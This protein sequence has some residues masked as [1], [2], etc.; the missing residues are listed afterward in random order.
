MAQLNPMLVRLQ[1]KIE[2]YNKDVQRKIDDVA[3]RQKLVTIGVV[4]FNLVVLFLSNYL[5]PDDSKDESL[6]LLSLFSNDQLSILIT[7]ISIGFSLSTASLI[8]RNSFKELKIDETIIEPKLQ[9]A[10][11]WEY[12]TEF[13]IQTKDDGSTEY[14]RF[15]DNMEDYKERGISYWT[16]DA[17]ELKIDFGNTSSLDKKNEETQPKLPTENASSDTDKVKKMPQV[18]WQSNPI[19]YD[20]HKV[21]WSFNGTIWWNDDKNYANEFS[22]IELYYVR[23]TDSQGRPSL[24]EGRLV[25]T[26]LVGDKFYV[27]DAIS[28]FWRK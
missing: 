12:L 6:R 24:L 5:L 19:A 21:S 7:V 25:G 11:E 13:R 20:E 3:N 8:G 14:K 26:I 4:C 18:N 2:D 16:Q 23:G 1:Q 17:F 22:G 15:K 28:S 10:G 9:Y 27:V